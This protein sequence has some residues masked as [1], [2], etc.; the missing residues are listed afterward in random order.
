MTKVLIFLIFSVYYMSNRHNLEG[1]SIVSIDGQVLG[2]G[3]VGGVTGGAVSTLTNTGSPIMVGLIVAG[4]LIV[5]AGLLV[6]KNM[7]K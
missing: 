4:V 7:T 3:T 5:V 1:I 6:R 2:V